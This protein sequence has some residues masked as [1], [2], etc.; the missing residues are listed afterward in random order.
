MIE[1]FKIFQG[2]DNIDNEIFFSLNLSKTRGHSYKLYKGPLKRKYLGNIFIVNVQLNPGTPYPQK[3][4]K[5]LVLLILNAKSI[6]ISKKTI[7]SKFISKKY[8]P[9]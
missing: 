9:C 3:L 2:L 5:P 4:Q 7:S 6:P 1:T 8:P